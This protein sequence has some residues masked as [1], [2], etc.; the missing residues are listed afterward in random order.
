MERIRS[1]SVY[2]GVFPAVLEYLFAKVGKYLGM[3]LCM[4]VHTSITNIN[5]RMTFNGGFAHRSGTA[6]RAKAGARQNC[7]Y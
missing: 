4:Y 2:L 5:K 7:G 6:L 3:Y 1:D